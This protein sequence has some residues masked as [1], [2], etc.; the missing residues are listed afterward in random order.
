MSRLAQLATGTRCNFWTIWQGCL[1]CWLYL[2]GWYFWCSASSSYSIIPESLS[3]LQEP[4]KSRRCLPPRNGSRTTLIFEGLPP[5]N[6]QNRCVSRKTW[7]FSPSYLTVSTTWE[8]IVG[9]IVRYQLDIG[10]I[11]LD[12]ELTSYPKIT[13]IPV[14]LRRNIQSVFRTDG[15]CVC[16]FKWT[17]VWKKEPLFETQWPFLGVSDPLISP[18]MRELSGILWST[19]IP[20]GVSTDLSE[21]MLNWATTRSHNHMS[22]LL[23]MMI[24]VSIYYDT[25][26]R[27]HPAPPV[28]LSDPITY[29]LWA[30]HIGCWY[31]I[32]WEIELFC[33][34]EHLVATQE[35][36]TWVLS[37]SFRKCATLLKRRFIPLEIHGSVPHRKAFYLSWR[38]CSAWSD[39][40]DIDQVVKPHQQVSTSPVW[41]P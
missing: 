22:S 21:I 23:A 37:M 25:C 7:G 40:K 11:I 31:R 26:K 15:L 35:N 6:N 29:W 34:Y 2:L 3:R 1:V 4:G 41:S 16:K 30:S 13:D 28:I 24:Y 19:G 32:A 9:K 18:P 14:Q 17:A 27:W 20:A 39:Y 8:Y 38:Y 10:I 5:Y 36:R 33:L 12:I